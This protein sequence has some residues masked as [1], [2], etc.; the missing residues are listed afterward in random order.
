MSGT[1]YP[2]HDDRPAPERMIEEAQRDLDS[3]QVQLRN[4]E[5]EIAKSKAWLAFLLNHQKAA[6]A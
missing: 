6:K 4:L 2:W 3:K 5:Y 1:A